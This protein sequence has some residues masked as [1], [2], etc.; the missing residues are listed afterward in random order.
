MPTR[1]M[2]DPRLWQSE[3]IAALT[4]NQRLLFI[5]IFSNADDQG[6][7][8]AHPALIRSL[9][10]PFDDIPLEEIECDLAAIAQG[11]SILLYDVDGKRCLQVLNW[12]E[13]QTPQWAYPS[14]MPPPEGWRDRLR[15]RQ[16]NHVIKENWGGEG[17]GEPLPEPLPKTLPNAQGNALDCAH[18]VRVSTSTSASPSPAP[19]VAQPDEFP[20]HDPPPPAVD[21]HCRLTGERVPGKEGG[22]EIA[23]TVGTEPRAPDGWKDVI[24]AWLGCDWKP[25]DIKGML[26]CFARG[27]ILGERSS[28]HRSQFDQAPHRGAIAPVLAAESSALATAL[29]ARSQGRSKSTGPPGT[30]PPGPRSLPRSCRPRSRRRLALF[31]ISDYDPAVE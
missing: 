4:R 25:G 29:R 21:L 1:R 17:L 26:D 13:Y 9:L 22:D 18:S 16:D 5:G 6:R 19:I 2:I 12:W 3:T 20:L 24:H 7:L 8:R 31:S 27:E 14:K 23:P 10:F 15:Y 30:G 11:E 28:G